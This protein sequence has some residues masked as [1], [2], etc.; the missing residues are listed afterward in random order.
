MRQ[1]LRVLYCECAH[2]AV[3][4]AQAK[5][6]VRQA[7]TE[8]GLPC[9]AVPDLCRLAAQNSPVLAE[10]AGSSRLAIAAC[11]PR[12]VTWLFAAGGAP[13]P[14]G[15]VVH[16]DMRG[17]SSEELVRSVRALAQGNGDASDSAGHL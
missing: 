2:A 3:L 12:A 6:D 7:L 1:D 14:D 16:L 15:R 10:L 17:T 4:S 13:L 8:T 5:Q 11:H 9:L